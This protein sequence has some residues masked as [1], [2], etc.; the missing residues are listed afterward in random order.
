LSEDRPVQG[1]YDG[2]RTTDIAVFR[3]HEGNWYVIKSTGGAMIRNWGDATD[4]P[5]PGDYDGDGKFDIAVWRPSQGT[6][7]II[8]SGNNTGTQHYLGLSTDT[9]IPSAYVP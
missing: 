7:Y 5:V 6:W 8:H 3:P 4:K 9:P 2:D 1:D